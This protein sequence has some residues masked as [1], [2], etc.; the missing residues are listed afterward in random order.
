M[1]QKIFGT[2]VT[3]LLLSVA[4]AGPAHAAGDCKPVLDAMTKQIGTPTHIYMTEATQLHGGKSTK[5]E[6]IHTGSAIYIQ[7]NGQ[8]R[9]SPLST[10]DLQ[11]QREEAARKTKSMSCRY[12]RD[13][14]VNG[15]PAAVYHAQTDIED[16]KSDSTVW[17][18]KR[19]GL[20]LRT[21]Q[22]TDTG[23]ATGMQHLSI[24]FDYANVQPPAGV[25]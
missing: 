18:S 24:R 10:Q 21:E 1:S 20:P 11:K 19:T 13:E 25:K 17:V 6:A 3:A 7:M 8:W 12:L 2:L 15:E 16:V 9:R 22:D 14:P 5:K 23:G 4:L